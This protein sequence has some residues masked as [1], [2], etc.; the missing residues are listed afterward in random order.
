M[1]VLQNLKFWNQQIR[2]FQIKDFEVDVTTTGLGKKEIDCSNFIAL[3]PA[4]DLHVHFREPGFE[5]K[6]NMQS[7]AFAALH[8]GIL[9]VLDMPNTNPITDST[10]A[11]L[12]KKELSSKQKWIEILVAA[13][14]TNYNF[15]EIEGLDSHCD[16]Y[17]VFMSE[18]FGNL[19]ISYE[20]IENS[21]VKLESI[22]SSKPIIFHAEDPR[23]I[24]E[25]K[26]ENNHS[27]K[28]PP[29]AEAFA[30]QTVLK[31]ASDFP[32]LKFHLTHISSSLSLKFLDLVDSANLTS[33]TCPRY[34]FLNEDSSIPQ[35]YKKV[36]PPLRKISDN[37]SLIESLATGVVDM[38]SSDHSPHTLAEKEKENPSGMPGVQ[39]LLPAL[40]TLVKNMEIEWDRAIEAFHYLPSK[41][42]NLETD[43]S[44]NSFIV[45]DINEPFRVDKSWIKSKAKWSPFE[46]SFLYGKIKHIVKNNS[47]IQM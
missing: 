4:I 33:D 31:W 29:E 19:S 25:S 5:H 17:K 14:L 6:E 13:A 2:D 15:D 3:P 46:N 27:K 36:N 40:L 37:N 12:Q 42:L 34:L 8:G 35:H 20:N 26:K 7:G 47:L 30:V 11:V 45:L 28:R 21:L 16:A 43:E 38:I 41:L 23:I 1:V 39:E 10:K 32:S 22:E 24:E 9:H 44:L 18:S